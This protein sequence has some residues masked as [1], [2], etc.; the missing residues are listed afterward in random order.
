MHFSPNFR[1][2][3]GKS[4]DRVRKTNIPTLQRG[5]LFSKVPSKR[6]Y[7]L[8]L[9]SLQKTTTWRI[10][11]C[12]LYMAMI[13]FYLMSSLLGPQ[14]RWVTWSL[15]QEI[16]H[17]CSIELLGRNDPTCVIYRLIVSFCVCFLRDTSR[18]TWRFMG[19]ASLP[20]LTKASKRVVTW[21]CV[22]RHAHFF[23]DERNLHTLRLFTRRLWAF[24]RLE[25][26]N[27]TVLVVNEVHFTLNF[28]DS[29]V[30]QNRH[31]EN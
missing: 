11:N 15:C 22:G 24:L 17:L 6:P 14:S 29:F 26:F 9:F 4:K 10:M 5:L 31:L 20:S 12:L 19:N 25:P 16:V 23:R 27:R 13:L 7:H 30:N 18:Q 8:L 1:I 3:K 2:M 21:N 28:M